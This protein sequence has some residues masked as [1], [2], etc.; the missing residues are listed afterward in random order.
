MNFKSKLYI[1]V[2]FFLSLS[3]LLSQN[4]NDLE[5]KYNNANGKPKIELGNQLS[6]LYL[7]SNN[8]KSL[9]FAQLTVILANDMNDNELKLIAYY[10]L[11]EAN[12]NIDHKSQTAIDINKNALEIANLLHNNEK[13]VVINNLLGVIYQYKEFYYKSIEYFKVAE[14]ISLKTNVLSDQASIYNNIA[15]SYK[16]L[17]DIEKSIVYFLKSLKIMTQN[18]NILSQ[19]GLFNNI[20]NVY[21]QLGNLTKALEFYENALKISDKIEVNN[22]KAK[23]LNNLAIVHHKLGN[24][25]KSMTYYNHSINIKIKIGD[26]SSLSTSYLNLGSL[27]LEKSDFSNSLIQFNK[28]LA[29][30]K[31]LNNSQV[32]ANTYNKIGELYLKQ[33]NLKESK[34]NFDRAFNLAKEIKNKYLIKDLY[35]SYS[36]YYILLGDIKK[37]LEYK[38]KFIEAKDSIYNID[39]NLKLN[40]MFQRFALEE[41]DRELEASKKE[42]RIAYLES[43]NQ[44]VY[45]YSLTVVLILLSII[46]IIVVNRYNHI[47]KL[48]RNLEIQNEVLTQTQKEL[49]AQNIALK[50]ADDELQAQNEVLTQTQ[51]E[52]ITQNIALKKADDELHAKNEELMIAEADLK[53]LLSEQTFIANMKSRYLTTNAHEFKSPLTSILNSL[54]NI[55]S[56]FNERNYDTLLRAKKIIII[57]VNS[58][59]TQLE[60]TLFIERNNLKKDIFV[61]D[62]IDFVSVIKEIILIQEVNDDNKHEIEFIS[63][64]ESVVI[65][66]DKTAINR[67]VSNLISNA[68]KYSKR[69]S[70]VIV[71]LKEIDDDVELSVK[72]FGIGIPKDEQN[73]LF[74]TFHRFSNA[75]DIIGTGIGLNIVK[76]IID[77]VKGKIEVI[78]DTNKGTEI[79]IT[80]SKII[81]FIQLDD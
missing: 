8:E 11:A 3:E 25:D 81:N 45:S 56:S 40:G 27:Y 77:F 38:D 17:G 44:K 53:G 52:L 64:V 15:I 71:S 16:N 43:E 76:R 74:E 9:Y 46:I 28:A 55:A 42:Q 30:S 2:L 79:I 23:I 37:S 48:E 20:G 47:K 10:N 50:K 1:T 75:K 5:L 49:I 13:I 36:D 32:E 62:K 18:K 35:E 21:F 39:N 19:K 33:S 78:S 66:F 57:S 51:K 7:H 59:R 69:N 14:A 60:N 70:K 80:F 34:L 26:K 58:L 31:L 72:D 4:F 41:K 61:P 24:F 65:F 73:K 12:F 68:L 67:M 6:E 54:E 29:L 22:E 63:N